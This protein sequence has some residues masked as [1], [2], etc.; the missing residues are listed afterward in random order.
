MLVL[1]L[2]TKIAARI[3]DHL[4]SVASTNYIRKAVVYP[5]DDFIQWRNHCMKP[6]AVDR[7]I[8]DLWES[9]VFLDPSDSFLNQLADSHSFLFRTSFVA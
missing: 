3:E 2:T 5:N 9:L 7:S 1:K 6:T 8:Y 4:P